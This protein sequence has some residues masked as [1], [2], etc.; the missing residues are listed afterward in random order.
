MINVETV[1][2]EEDNYVRDKRIKCLSLHELASSE[3]FI[4]NI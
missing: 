4:A 2:G 3:H 1:K